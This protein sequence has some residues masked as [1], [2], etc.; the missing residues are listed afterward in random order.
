[1][2]VMKA[3]QVSVPGGNMELVEIPIPEPG[4]KQVLIRVEACGVCHGDSKVVEGAA[5]SYPRIPGH[6]VVG[7]VAKTG[8]GTLNWRIGQ[9]VG[10]GW[11]GG[12]GH[13]T[14]LTMNGGYAEYMI[15]YEDGL[16][17]IPEELSPRRRLLCS[18]R[19]KLYS[20]L[21]GTARRV[22][23]IWWRFPASAVWGILQFSMRKRPDMKPSP[24]PAER[25]RRCWRRNSVRITMWTP[26]RKSRRRH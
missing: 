12:H 14:A 21:C 10:V 1:M 4:E 16:I 24:F 20:A 3:V 11:H 15:A 7:T 13:T 9:R 2:S 25:I 6:E 23:A 26:Q 5:S 19:E 18:A 17:A 8:K 22:P